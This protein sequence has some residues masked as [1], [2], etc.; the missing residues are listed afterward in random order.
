MDLRKLLKDKLEKQL[1]SWNAEIESAEAKARAKHAEA[2][3]EAADA[4]LE[5][6]LWSRVNDLKDKASKGRQYLADLMDSGDR[7]LDEV[8]RKV[9]DLVD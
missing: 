8:K 6:E 5:K 3:S 1:E 4:E 7:K 2:E 9:S